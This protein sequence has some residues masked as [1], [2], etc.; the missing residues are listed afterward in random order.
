MDTTFNGQMSIEK[1]CEYFYKGD[2]STSL[3]FHRHGFAAG[4]KL[5]HKCVPLSKRN[6]ENLVCIERTR[7]LN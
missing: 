7:I 3:H 1:R 6:D 5:K 4:D 2:E